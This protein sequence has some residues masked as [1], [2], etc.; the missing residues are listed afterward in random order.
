[1][2]ESVLGISLFQDAIALNGEGDNKANL[3]M[4]SNRG[5]TVTF[6][7]NSV[8][9]ISKNNNAKLNAF[10]LTRRVAFDT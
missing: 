9:K 5:K 4:G 10:W 1:L 3:L 6:G 2:A 8:L 7:P